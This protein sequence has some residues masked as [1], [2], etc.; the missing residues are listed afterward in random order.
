MSKRNDLCIPK[1]KK[2]QSLTGLYQIELRRGL[3][4]A[5]PANARAPM[6][7][8]YAS[9]PPAYAGMQTHFGSSW[10]TQQEPTHFSTIWGPFFFARHGARP[11]KAE[12]SCYL[13][14]AAVEWRSEKFTNARRLTGWG[15]DSVG[16]R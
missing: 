14:R 13:T 1:G 10:G 8:A 2:G 6:Q 11:L 7:S 16:I 4:S 3:L 9:M 15:G 5:G 12:R